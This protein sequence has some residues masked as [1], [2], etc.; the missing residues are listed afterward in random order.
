MKDFTV[1]LTPSEQWHYIV[2]TVAHHYD[3]SAMLWWLARY[4][5]LDEAFKAAV[6]MRDGMVAS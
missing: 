1:P 2:S 6:D 5:S 4:E 3:W